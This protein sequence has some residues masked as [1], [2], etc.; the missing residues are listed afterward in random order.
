[1]TMTPEECRTA[2][3]LLGWSR[4]RLGAKAM[5]SESTVRDF[6]LGRRLRSARSIPRLQEALEAAGV[7]FTEAGV[8]L[9]SDRS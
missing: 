7:A 4:T 3:E 6:E 9:E 5:L 1:M 8:M 2:R